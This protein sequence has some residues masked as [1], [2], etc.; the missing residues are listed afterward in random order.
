MKPQIA[1]HFLLFLQKKEEEAANGQ[2]RVNQ[3]I[4]AAFGFCGEG[5]LPRCPANERDVEV[6]KPAWTFS[7]AREANGL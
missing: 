7:L 6:I 2:S 3:L 1:S 5:K 4:D